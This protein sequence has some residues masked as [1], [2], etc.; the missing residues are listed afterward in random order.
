MIQVLIADDHSIFRDGLKRLI[1]EAPGMEVVG[2]AGS[3]SETLEVAGKVKPDVVLCDVVM[4]GRGPVETIQGLR[5]KV[6]DVRILML[7][8]QPEDHFALRCLKEGAAG[9]LSK[10][11]LTTELIE[12][13]RRLAA[14]GR[15]VSE[16]LAETLVF[17]LDPDHDHL[18]HQ[19][20]SDREFQVML[21]IAKGMPSRE[22]AEELSL[23]IKTISTYRS[24]ILEKM[25]LKN[26]AELMLY[27][28][29]HGLV[30]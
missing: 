4:P 26:N 14:G 30:T 16:A 11:S 17:S 22:I 27:A 8:G 10:A 24:R 28:I 6:P 29:R 23:S 25:N 21:L 13:I 9:Y 7:T 19:K 20:L 3:S 12:A 1:E 15:Y 2:E 18:P 5:R